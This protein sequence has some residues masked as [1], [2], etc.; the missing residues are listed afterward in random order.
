MGGDHREPITTNRLQ[1]TDHREPII[2][3]RGVTT[4]RYKQTDCN[5][6]ITTQDLNNALRL[7]GADYTARGQRYGGA[8]FLLTKGVTVL[9]INQQLRWNPR[10]PVHGYTLQSS[11]PLGR[12]SRDDPSLLGARL[13]SRGPW[14]MGV[15]GEGISKSV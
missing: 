3:T 14:A 11:S 6:P 12:L 9:G 5:E 8:S 10:D 2:T 4:N 15:S 13:A 1:R 7:A